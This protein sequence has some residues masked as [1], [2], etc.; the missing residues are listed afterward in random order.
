MSSFLVCK[1]S[2]FVSHQEVTAYVS[3]V[4]ATKWFPQNLGEPNSTLIHGYLSL[5]QKF[6][7][8]NFS[9]GCG[10][11]YWMLFSC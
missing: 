1:S 2:R 9:S 3:I 4:S 8:V 10:R 11:P 7:W 6:L 5:G